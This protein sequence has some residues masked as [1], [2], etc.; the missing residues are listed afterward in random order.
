MLFGMI[1]T[2]IPVLKLQCP[3]IGVFEN[4]P[5]WR[6][7]SY[8][9]GLHVG[10]CVTINRKPC[11]IE[12]GQHIKLQFPVEFVSP[13]RPETLPDQFQTRSALQSH[14]GTGPDARRSAVPCAGPATQGHRV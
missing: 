13:V 5:V 12:S 1:G 2:S 10:L 6:M 9:C 14:L 7:S 8:S 11:Q 3:S 4:S